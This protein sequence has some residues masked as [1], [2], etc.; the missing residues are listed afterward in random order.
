[1]LVL[2]L[3]AYLFGLTLSPLS[4]LV[5]LLGAISHVSGV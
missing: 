3:P 5:C 2:I 1:M 4:S